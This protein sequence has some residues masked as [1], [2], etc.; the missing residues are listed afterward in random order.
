[1]PSC[2]L[3]GE[4]LRARLIPSPSLSPLGCNAGGSEEGGRS[5]Y[6]RSDVRRPYLE[7]PGREGQGSSVVWKVTLQNEVCLRLAPAAKPTAS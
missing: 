5:L 7:T 1:M 3:T 4:H 6:G 2:A